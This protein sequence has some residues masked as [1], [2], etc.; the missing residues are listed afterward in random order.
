MGSF[1]LLSSLLE[2]KEKLQILALLSVWDLEYQQL[3]FEQ[4][5][6]LTC[7]KDQG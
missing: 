5:I 7:N 1:N 3:Q 6:H 2:L 4:I